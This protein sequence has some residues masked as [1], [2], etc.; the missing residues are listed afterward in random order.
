MWNSGNYNPL[1]DCLYNMN[2]SDALKY[3][4]GYADVPKNLAKKRTE[5]PMMIG[6]NRDEFWAFILAHTNISNFTKENSEDYLASK[7]AN[8]FG[9][10]TQQIIEVLE[11]LYLEPSTTIDDHLAWVKMLD[12]ICTA[13]FFTGGAAIDVELHLSNNN[14]NVFV[15]Q[16]TY[17]NRVAENTGYYRT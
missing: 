12:Y 10:Q 6:S 8:F 13:F 14:S 7:F 15:Y 2:V 1:K 16:F 17:A 9:S 11:N 5:K 4:Y 3:N